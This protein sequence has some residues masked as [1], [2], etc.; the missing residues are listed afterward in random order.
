[1]IL[2]KE[3]L[4]IWAVIATR[5][6]AQATLDHS[7]RF[8]A[9]PECQQR[10]K[11]QPNGATKRGAQAEEHVAGVIAAI[12]TSLTGRPR[13]GSPCSRDARSDN[14]HVRR[15]RKYGRRRRRSRAEPIRY[16]ESLQPSRRVRS[17]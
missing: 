6:T 9:N 2:L 7:Q 12:H 4:K 17:P 5:G 1:M 15:R 10:A 16:R 11:N 14:S 8:L 13:L 3:H